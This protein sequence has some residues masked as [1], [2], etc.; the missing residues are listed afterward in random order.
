LSLFSRASEFT[1]DDL[2]EMVPEYMRRMKFEEDKKRKASEEIEKQEEIQTNI[3][4]AMEGT[5]RETTL[6]LVLFCLFVVGWVYSDSIFIVII[7][8]WKVP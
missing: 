3:D 8:L 2:F 7:Y 6:R 4:K 5:D 1:N